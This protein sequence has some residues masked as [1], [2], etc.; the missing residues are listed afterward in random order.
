MVWG[1]HYKHLT[2]A[3]LM[4]TYNI[5][6]YGE[7]MK[8]ISKLHVSSNTHLICSTKVAPGTEML[9]HE[10]VVMLK[11]KNI[12]HLYSVWQVGKL[13][14]HL[15]KMHKVPQKKEI[16][17]KLAYLTILQICCSTFYNIKQ[18]HK[19]SKACIFVHDFNHIW[20]V[21]VN[22]ECLAPT[23]PLETCKFVFLNKKNAVTSNCK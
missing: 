15:K 2:E 10:N 18:C 6:F 16:G 12:V 9:L 3:I 22:F 14:W 8:V 7:L 1:A 4:S 13:K 5:C 20:W 11:L 17:Q 21:N 23:G 19:K